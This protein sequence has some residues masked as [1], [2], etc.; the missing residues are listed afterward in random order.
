MSQ[1]SHFRGVKIKLPNLIQYAH[2]L[3]I[4]II[5]IHFDLVEATTT[6]KGT[7]VLSVVWNDHNEKQYPAVWLR[8]NC[9]CKNCYQA[10]ALARLHL[11][12]NV[13]PEIQF[14]NLTV[15]NNEVN[16]HIF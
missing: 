13:D 16:I 12:R 9:Q 6:P 1:Q 11:M 14:K 7:N 8:D 10:S 2:V 3:K 15:E 5:G 4:F